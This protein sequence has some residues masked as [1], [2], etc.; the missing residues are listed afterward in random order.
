M[1]RMRLEYEYCQWYTRE[2]EATQMDLLP[3]WKPKPKM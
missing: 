3:I 1:K 2:D